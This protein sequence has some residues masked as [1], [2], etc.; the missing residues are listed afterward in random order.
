MQRLARHTY[1]TIAIG[2][3]VSICWKSVD[4]WYPDFSRGFLLNKKDIFHFYQFGLYAHIIAAP[5]AFFSGMVQVC[6]PQNKFHPAIGSVYVFSVLFLA[7]P[8]GLLMSFFAIGGLLSTL[9]FALLSVLWGGYTFRAYQATL[10]NNRQQHV[11]FIIGSFILTQSAIL[12]RL[13]SYI[14]HQADLVPGTD[15]YLLVS[16]LSWLPWIVGYEMLGRPG[17]SA[18]HSAPTG[19]PAPPYDRTLP[20]LRDS[21]LWRCRAWFDR[22]TDRRGT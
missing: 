6:F 17:R 22:R 7:A 12:L 14:N 13:F 18:M 15:G 10:Q 5:V 21:I 19:T 3:V 2:M 4:Y 20:A 16:V 1:Y 9:N 8:S 11:R